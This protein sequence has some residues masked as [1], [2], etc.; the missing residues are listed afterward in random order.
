[1]ILGFPGLTCADAFAAANRCFKLI[2]HQ[3]PA[4]LCP[5]S[6]AAGIISWMNALTD[7]QLLRD[8]AE[9]RSEAA[10]AELVRRHVDLVHSAARRMTG[11]AHSAEDVTQTVFVA[12]AQNA[13]RLAEHPVLSGWLHTTARHLAAK[14][15]RVT[16]RRQL[17]EQEAAAMNPLLSAENEIPWE[18]VA[19]CL[20]AAL[21]ELNEIERDALLLRYFEKKSAPE[22]AALLGISNA[23]AQKRVSR[24]V[25]RL[26]EFFAQRGLTAGTGGLAVVIN[27]NAVQAAPLGLAVTIFRR[28]TRAARRFPLPQQLP[29]PPMPL[30]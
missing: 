18:H 11:E 6:T 19:P 26:R 15:V 29:P 7:Q 13:A 17:R 4:F 16:V 14:T 9:R 5:T 8:Y 12:L 24:A 3:I 30:L 25:E 1:M 27:A 21:G 23:A 28:R 10:F 22:I 2:T 20:D